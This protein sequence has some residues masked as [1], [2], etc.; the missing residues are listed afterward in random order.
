MQRRAQQKN[1]HGGVS[2]RKTS[3]GNGEPQLR[4]LHLLRTT[5]V[6]FAIL[7]VVAALAVIAVFFMWPNSSR[8]AQG[9]QVDFVIAPGTNS[10]QIAADLKHAGLIGNETIFRFRLQ[11]LGAGSNL[12]AGTHLLVSG[13]SY[14]RIILALSSSPTS[15]AVKVVIPEGS[16]IARIA[17]ILHDRLGLSAAAFEAY[18]TTAASDFKQQYPYLE[19]AYN[20][21]LEGYLFP[22]TYQFPK[23]STPQEICAEM[24]GRFDQVWAGLQPSGHSNYSIAQLVTVA[25]L[26][27][28]E[29]SV[30]T[31][32]PLVASVIYNR[33]D[34]N[35]R[36]QLCST[37]Q[38][39]LPDPAKNKL[40][41]TAVD[42]ATPS[43]YNTYLH[44]GLPPGPIANPGK[45]ALE[46]ALKPA[47]TSYLYFV[48]TG[49]DGSQT[50][51]STSAEFETAKLKSKEVFGQ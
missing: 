48:L 19:S 32:R 1:L 14:E 30:P 3:Q 41:L 43:P 45:A 51:A 33:L 16:N 49:K 37:V 26:V 40:R 46:A 31:E 27:E 38:I 18:A 22:D 23:S 47:Q 10:T 29:V 21:S 34:R 11:R 50:F 4:R 17:T 6:A 25:S 2:R 13:W 12:I 42:L 36:L 24:L 44:A 7:C 15:T 5:L 9:T 35:M 8:L 28:K 39:L 20:G